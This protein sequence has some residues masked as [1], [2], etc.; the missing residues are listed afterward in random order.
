MKELIK[1]ILLKAGASDVGIVKARVFDELLPMISNGSA[2]FSDVDTEKRINPFLIDRAAKSIIVFVVSYKSGLKGNISSY[3]FGQDYHTVLKKIASE[4]E[5]LLNEKG[6][7]AKTFADTGDL[8]D[9]HLAYLAGLGFLG[10]N[11]CLIHPKFGSFVFIGHIITDCPLPEDSPLN[12][13]CNNC[14]ACLD[15]CPSH[16]LVTGDFNTCLSF[17]TQKK[18]ELTPAEETLIKSSGVIWGCDI[19]Q[20]VCPHNKNVPNATLPEFSTDLIQTLTLPEEITNREFRE[21]YKDRAFCWRG[22]NVL[23]RNLKLMD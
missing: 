23:I 20:N 6:F 8:P 11:H 14:G 17:I 16:A 15:A 2:C 3:A 13:T 10:K 22:K 4:A 12:L 9:R 18:G 21:L 5:T 19:C 1:K 7:S